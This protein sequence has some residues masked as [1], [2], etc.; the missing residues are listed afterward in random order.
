MD[1]FEQLEEIAE[2]ISNNKNN[3]NTEE[4]TKT[5]FVLPFLSAL[6]YD[7]FNPTQVVPEY[8]A[9][10]DGKKGEKVD[11]CIFHEKIPTIIIECKHWAEDLKLHTCQ[12]Q[13][14]FH[15]TT[16]KFGILTN[17]IDYQFFTDL[18]DKNKLDKKPF[19]EFS[20]NN[21][22]E[23]IAL[24]VKK[25]HQE[26]FSIDDIFNS[27]TDLKYS[28][29][30]KDLLDQELKEPS[31]DFVKYFATRVCEKKVTKKVFEQFEILV[32]KSTNQL[33][34]ELVS[35]RLKTALN[36]EEEKGKI[37]D[38]EADAELKS[39]GEA[40]AGIVT[41]PEEEEG[42]RI[43]QAITRRRVNLERI[44]MRDQKSYCGILLDDNNR[45][46]VC[47]LHFNSGNKYL[48]LIDVSKGINAKHE[49]KIY[50]EKL[51][52]IFSH[53]EALLTTIDNYL[54]NE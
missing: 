2:R 20:F 12:L 34:R 7:I 1:F 9:D 53:E 4:A 23:N 18:D 44:V 47:R 49:E 30:I 10:I 50:I 38:E 43:V 8:I 28:K 11:Y 25:F 46:P 48:G 45:K 52:D 36:T 5:S 27:A 17:G 21:L 26:N 31:E 35:E 19:L 22:N 24:E 29:G 33:I 13:R 42:Y 51:E 37:N 16:A 15:V 40:E 32:K 3:V 54:K 41:T 6:G 39:M 14:Y